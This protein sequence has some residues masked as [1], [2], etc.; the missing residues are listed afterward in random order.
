M[1]SIKQF[2]KRQE[3]LDYLKNIQIDMNNQ[4]VKFSD[5]TLESTADAL[6]VIYDRSNK[7][8]EEG[9]PD[10]VKGYLTD[11]LSIYLLLHHEDSGDS[12]IEVLP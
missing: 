9:R 4:G 12:T 11:C 3:I 6:H 1:R 5:D 10:R 2:G 7:L 8:E